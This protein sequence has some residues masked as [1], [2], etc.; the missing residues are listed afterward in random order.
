MAR[1]LR[2]KTKEPQ[3]ITPLKRELAVLRKVNMR[4]P[5]M[6]ARERDNMQSILALTQLEPGV[7]ESDMSWFSEGYVSNDQARDFIVTE[8]LIAHTLG[9]AVARTDT[10]EIVKTYGKS[11][12]K[13]AEKAVAGARLQLS[14]DVDLEAEEDEPEVEDF[15]EDVPADDED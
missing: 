5:G 4:F 13:A 15:D 3:Q 9:F 6:S 8:A 14:V 7:P 1:T 11:N 10:G 12:L 2:S